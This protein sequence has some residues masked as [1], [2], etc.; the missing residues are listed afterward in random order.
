M[1]FNLCGTKLKIIALYLFILRSSVAFS[2][3]KLSLQQAIEI[4]VKQNLRIQHSEIQ[5]KLAYADLQKAKFNMYP[6]LNFFNTSSLNFGRSLSLTTYDY[7]NQ[8]SLST[9]QNIISNFVIFQGAQKRNQIKK[10]EFDLKTTES[11]SIKDKNNLKLNVISV[12]LNILKYKDQLKAA[13]Q[14]ME[15]NQ[16][17]LG[18]ATDA[19]MGGKILLSDLSRAKS[20]LAITEFN[21][22]TIQK[23]LNMAEL[24]LL[25]LLNL[26]PGHSIEIEDPRDV[27]VDLVMKKYDRSK[28][29]QNALGFL[30]E[31]K[32]AEFV[33]QSAKQSVSISQGSFY[34]KLTLSGSII[35]N[36]TNPLDFNSNLGYDPVSFL[37][38]IKLN[39]YEYVSI[40]LSIPI[41]NYHNSTISLKKARLSLE[42]A[43]INEQVVKNNIYRE[44]TEALYDLQSSEKNYTS[45]QTQYSAAVDTYKIMQ[46]RY[47]EG[48]NSSLELYQALTDMNNAQFRLIYSK[49][50][51]I[52]QTKVMGF[53]AGEP[54]NY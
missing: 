38:Q 37:K 16:K 1:K 40:N 18:S 41:Y 2:Q 36:S 42:D 13:L 19:F 26:D 9:T 25:Q 11:E 44:L 31:I 33:T 35:S 54:I 14:Q 15:L 12:Y 51:L 34:P 20:N 43:R 27:E 29:F 7:I 5:K 53:Y 17:Y 6:D 45:A 48:A 4:S 49:Y 46:S 10:S 47:M 30:P 24:D 50:E 52:F 8:K 3:D 28:I 21:I 22:T 39:L 32:Q 23:Q